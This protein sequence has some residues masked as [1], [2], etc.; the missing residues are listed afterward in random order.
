MPQGV[1]G[2]AVQ[3]GF[4]SSS[5]AGLELFPETDHGHP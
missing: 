2:G 4:L 1:G 5:E 3:C